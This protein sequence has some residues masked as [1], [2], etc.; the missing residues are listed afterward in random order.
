METSSETPSKSPKASSMP[1]RVWVTTVVSSR[2][3]RQS[4]QV[5]VVDLIYDENGNIVG[6]M[7]AQLNKLKV[8]KALGSLPAGPGGGEGPQGPRGP[9]GPGHGGGGPAG[10]RGRGVDAAHH[11]GARR[12]QPRHSNH[13]VHGATVP[14]AVSCSAYTRPPPA[15]VCCRTQL[16]GGGCA[17][18]SG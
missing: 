5:I 9:Q 15:M 1:S 10:D 6:V 4:R 12:P 3:M 2:W 17:R 11:P 13:D 16:V 8:A 18:P 14:L 7:D